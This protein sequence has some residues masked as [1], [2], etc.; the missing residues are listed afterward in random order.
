MTFPYDKEPRK[1]KI[2]VTEANPSMVRFTL[3]D[4]DVSV[5]NALRRIILAEVPTLAIEIVNI[6][7]N[8][9]VLFD[10]FLA[11]R[12]GLLPLSCHSAGDIPPDNGY[13]EFKDCNCFDGCP[14]C[15]VEFKLDV[16]NTEDKVKTVTH[17][18]ME[19]SKKYEWPDQPRYK[20]VR[21]A[22][23]RNEKFDVVTDTRDNGIIIAKL[24]KDQGLK[25]I[26]HARK[27][28][29]KYHAKWM[30]VATALYQFQP[31]IKLDKEAANTLSLDDKID[32]VQSC[33]RKCF[34]LDLEDMV[35][36]P[37]PN[38]CIFCDECVAKAKVY[39]KKDMVTVNM[40]TNM[41]HFTVEAVC[42]DGPRS[43][44]DVVRASLRVL[45]Y[46]MSVFIQDAY[47]DDIKDYLP[48]KPKE[49]V[50]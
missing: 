36:L 31:I 21:P 4:T 48:L 17:F 26:C 9:T 7:E 19:E 23:F 16:R 50:S 33:P 44:I 24:K 25:M 14:Y 13:L 42:P 12:M 38:D 11:H 2:K 49:R 5:A 28:I 41:F 30:P 27:G 35:I 10:E 22:P 20:Q 39:G 32:F 6:E 34:D 40:D 37:R 45:D 1:P 18:D 29:P 46:K 3:T 47:G 8:E 43:V 15:T